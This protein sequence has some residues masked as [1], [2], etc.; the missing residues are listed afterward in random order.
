MMM[1]HSGPTWLEIDLHALATNVAALRAHLA[2]GASLYAVVKANAYGHGA[3]EIAHAVLDAGAAGLCVARAAEGLTLRSAGIT[4]PIWVLGWVPKEQAR[5]CVDAGLTLTVNSD[6]MLAAVS[7]AAAGQRVPVHVKVDTGMS[8]FGLLP[9]EVLPFVRRLTAYPSLE[10]EGVWTHLASAD[11]A[12]FA[13][14]EEQMARF[15]E[16]LDDLRAAGLA[17][18]L[19]HTVASAG[20]LRHELRA[21]HFDVVRAGL[22]VYGLLPGEA[23][24][25]PISVE[26]VLTWKARVARVRRLPAGTPISYGGTYVT[27]H[28]M[29]V[30][31]VPVGYGDGYPRILSNRGHVL[32]HEK[33]CRILGRVCMDNFV[34]DAEPVP[35]VREGDEI[36][37][38]GRQGDEAIT[39][40]EL[41]GLLDT[42]N[43]EVVTQ[44]LDRVPRIVV[45]SR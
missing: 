14:T 24:D 13:P 25:W 19:C 9:Q 37:L 7:R 12:E 2:D 17:P 22:A 35:E 30:A 27:P 4:A 34:V 15:Q 32:I 40:D 42:I 5:Y 8:R 18:R 11:E 20:L 29:R 16:V 6:S 38:I 36:V 1:R 23:I 41:A 33:R 31:L 28:P 26:P 39:A 44:I 45:P 21:F 10:F 3:A 43:Y